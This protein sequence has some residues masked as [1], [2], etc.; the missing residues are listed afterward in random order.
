MTPPFTAPVS[1]LGVESLGP[2]SHVLAGFS[3]R[4]GGVSSSPY[5]SLNVSFRVGDQD[6]HVRENRRR[7]AAR[8]KGP[9]DRFVFSQIEHG[10]NVSTVGEAHAG[11]GADSYES[12]L[13][14]ADALITAT[15]GLALAI[16]V[17]DCVPL[18][19]HD[20]VTPAAAIA[21]GGWRGVVGHIAAAT[22]RAMTRAFDT[23]PRVVLAVIGPSAGP[24]TYAV[25]ATVAAQARATYPGVAVVEGPR[26][27]PRFNLWE[28]VRLDLLRAGCRPENV[29][30]TGI[31]TTLAHSAFFSARRSARTGR[32][33]AAISLRS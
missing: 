27:A 13:P 28:A 11:R 18:L 5:N 31:D 6:E 21:H 9:L 17:A 8:L 12:A 22:I 26:S 3:G 20:P 7:L 30:T 19:L 23:D 32:F 4:G 2:A 24:T 1:W 16:N 33:A 29:I 15:P 14:H 25:S 10:T